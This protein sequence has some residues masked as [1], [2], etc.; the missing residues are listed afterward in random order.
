MTK[1]LALSTVLRYPVYVLFV[2]TLL[3]FF[4]EAYAVNASVGGREAFAKEA[5]KRY[6]CQTS[7]P[8]K[9]G[10][11]QLP[12][13]AQ[14]LACHE[15]WL[16]TL[17]STHG[18]P[19]GKQGDF[20]GLQLDPEVSETDILKTERKIAK[21]FSQSDCQD[22]CVLRLWGAKLVK[23]R[24][25][26]RKTSPPLSFLNGELD[27]AVFEN[28]NLSGTEFSRS[29][30]INCLFAEVDLS[31]A[32]FEGSVLTGASLRRSKLDKTRFAGT[33]LTN[34]Y[35]ESDVAFVPAASSMVSAKGLQTLNFGDSP[36][37]EA[38]ALAIRDEFKRIGSREAL[39]EVNY[40]IRI[41]HAHYG[42]N[43][44]YWFNTVF[45]DF[46]VGYGLYPARPLLI[47]AVCIP[48][49]ALL[50]LTSMLNKG[51]AAGIFVV[52]DK[53]RVDKSNG[54]D[55][56]RRL[57]ILQPYPGKNPMLPREAPAAG[58]AN[59]LSWLTWQ[60]DED[61]KKLIRTHVLGLAHVVAF[62]MLLI[63]AMSGGTKPINGGGSNVSN[64]LA[65]T[66]AM[67]VAVIVSSLWLGRSGHMRK[68]W[69]M[70]VWFSVLSGFRFG[71]RDLSL[72]TW[73]ALLQPTEY[74]LKA[75]GWVRSAS[76]LQALL[77]LFFVGLWAFC[78]FIGPLE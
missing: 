61:R 65:W 26:N 11:I 70:A 32:N 77:G 57:T 29:S 62:G 27:G 78:Y 2:S 66:T 31:G 1:S 71:W 43:I 12:E 10:L 3:S 30:C 64:A 52:W 41:R 5:D 56:P 54:S 34:V 18:K 67:L 28:V 22:N 47:L 21:E 13:Y 42:T 23:F 50:Y 76:G 73:L 37:D 53:D 59:A 7:P 4:S 14:R 36:S 35:I 48:I 33:D 60:A 74:T 49:F 15:L 40:A 46:P 58:M 51:R 20:S 38:L 69:Q 24:M 44:E 17:I 72:G 25:A 68:A 63:W 6:G 19:L 75:S 45:F 16:T 9:A 55:K 39:R 8:P